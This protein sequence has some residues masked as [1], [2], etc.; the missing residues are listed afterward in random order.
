M[1][2]SRQSLLQQIA[3]A[4]DMAFSSE[5]APQLRELGFRVTL[6]RMAI[7]RVLRHSRGH[8]S[9]LE[10]YARA[11]RSVPGLTQPTVY[12]TLEFLAANGLAW[13]TN[14][15]NGHLVYELAK[16]NHSHI[17][18][19]ECGSQVEIDPRE[20]DSA[21]RKLAAITGYAV[22]QRHVNLSGLCPRCRKTKSAE[23]GSTD[24]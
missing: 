7:L 10:V 9:P 17:V 5:Y 23:G 13:Q 16:R 12:R 1:I 21:Y 14:L 4:I 20:L 24:A 11:R 19:R 15:A 6:Q 2:Y 22:D 8:L 3:I 18:C